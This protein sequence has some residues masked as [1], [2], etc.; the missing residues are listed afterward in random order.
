M[1]ATPVSTASAPLTRQAYRGSC[2]CGRVHYV[3]VISLP[4]SASIPYDPSSGIPPPPPPTSVRF[5]KCNCST[6]H[7]MGYLHVRVPDSPRAFY[8]LAPTDPAAEL[9][10]YTCGSGRVHWYFCRECGVRCFAVAGAGAGAVV[11]VDMERVVEGGLE[12]EGEGEG[13]KKV[14]KTT[15]AWVVKDDGWV[16]NRTGYL[17]INGLTLE[18]G[19]QGLDLRELKNKGWIEYLDRKED[20]HEGRFEYPHEG[21]T[22]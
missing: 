3:L 15:K 19:Q 6:C 13:G 5:Y 17:S 14:T 22:W 2:H 21:G 4:P 20:K 8:L 1:S 7:K 9:R 10:D 11:D 12:V 16:E 18:P